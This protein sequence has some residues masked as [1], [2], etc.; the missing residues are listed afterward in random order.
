MG[1]DVIV[2]CDFSSKE[3][4]MSFLDRFDGCVRKP[5]VKIGMELFYAEG[6]G[7]VRDI[8]SRGHKIFLDLKLHDIPNTVKK[9]MSVLSGLDVDM[10]NLHAAGTKAMM[11]AALEG[12]TRPDGT[13]P[14]LIAV[15]ML[16]ST[17]QRAMEEDLLIKEDIADVV[18]H[19]A[20]NAKECGLDGVVCSP[21]EAQKVHAACGNEFLT[22]TPGVRFADSDKGDQKRVM[23]PEEAKK[24]GSDYIVVGRPI[25]A[26]ADP[27]AAYERCV[28]EFVG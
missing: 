9:A 25:T 7:I 19:Y 20:R 11:T 4:V 2:A 1:K 24:I 8:K 10:C 18:M 15:T 17:D 14:I 6:P 16:T 12:L 26:A 28:R 27:V 13:R 21:L 23:T 3:Q 22:V 5:F